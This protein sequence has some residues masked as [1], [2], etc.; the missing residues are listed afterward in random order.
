MKIT[1]E[2]SGKRLDVYLSEVTQYTRSYI[3]QLS[4]EGHITVNGQKVKCGKILK[5]G[6]IIEIDAPQTFTDLKPQDIPFE[7]LYEDDDIAVINKPQGLTV[8]P[9]GRFTENTLVNALLFRL[10]SLSAI[11]GVYRPG[12]VHRLDKDT[13]GVMVVAK[14]DR[15]H[16]ELSRQIEKREVK[17]IYIAL[18]EGVVKEPHGVIDQRIGRSVKN[19]KLMAVTPDGREAIT[20]YEVIKRYKDNTLLRCRIHTGRTHQIRVH[21]K[22]IGHPVVGDKSYGYKKQRFDLKGQLL[23]ASSLEFSHPTKGEKM[24]FKADLPD[25]FKAVLSKLECAQQSCCSPNDE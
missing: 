3:K 24:C 9:S 10:K 15:A 21:L 2:T 19:R 23:H 14:T 11:N 17:K 1:A 7:M 12:I 25:Y 16:V 8:H 20:E 13:S 22:Y 6:E 4:D 18:V 5:G